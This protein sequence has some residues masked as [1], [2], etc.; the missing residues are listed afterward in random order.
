MVMTLR[1][2]TR[3]RL[4][5]HARAACPSSSTVQAPQIPEPHPYF[6]PVSCYSPRSVQSSSPSPSVLTVTGRPLRVNWMTLMSN[7]DW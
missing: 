6:V 5:T 4:V 3:A 1:P 7:A 2:W